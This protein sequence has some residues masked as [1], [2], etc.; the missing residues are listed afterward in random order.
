MVHICYNICCIFCSCRDLSPF[1]V[2]AVQSL[3]TCICFS[4]SVSFPTCLQ[5]SCSSTACYNCWLLLGPSD[6][7]ANYSNR[8]SDSF[9]FNNS[10]YCFL[11]CVYS[12]QTWNELVSNR[13]MPL[14]NCSKQQQIQVEVILDFNYC[15][16]TITALS[17]ISRICGSY[18]CGYLTIFGNTFTLLLGI[19]IYF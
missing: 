6:L 1:P 9:C 19:S 7:L 14:A 15:P 12:L 18:L 8:S 17:F 3:Y 4:I 5:L 10:L 16:S 11:L 2:S 13:K